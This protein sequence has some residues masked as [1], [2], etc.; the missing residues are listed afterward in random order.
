MA[1]RTYSSF[2]SSDT[3]SCE[4]LSAD[5]EVSVKSS[6][7]QSW[8]WG[9]KEGGTLLFLP[10]DSNDQLIIKL[11]IPGESFKTIS[12]SYRVG[13]CKVGRP[14]PSRSA[15]WGNSGC[16]KATCVLRNFM[17]MDTRTRRGSAARR[18]VPEEESAALQE[19]FCCSPPCPRGEVCC[20]VGGVL[21]LTTVSQRRSLLLCRRGSAARRRVPEEES[22]ALQEGICSSSPCPRGGVCRSAGCFKDGLQQ[23]SKRGN[24]C[25]GDFQSPTS[26]KRVL[27]PGNTVDYT[28]HNQRLF[29]EGAVPWQHNRL[30][31]AQPKAL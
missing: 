19:G 28:M 27:F 16:V 8:S 20:S 29:K 15:S 12:Y 14:E 22:A 7:S 13:H 3:E 18:R 5:E 10:S 9:L 23:R 1:G 11:Q 26:S 17:R 31:Y 6:G 21:L 2:L 4:S 25:V 30:H 24:P